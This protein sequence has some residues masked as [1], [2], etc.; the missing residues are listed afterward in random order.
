V[1]IHKAPA[2]YILIVLMAATAFGFSGCKQKATIK[3]PRSILDEKSATQEELMGIVNHYGKIR[4]LQARIKA[5]Y[6]S[7]LKEK[8][9]IELEKYPKAPG[10]IVL[11]RPDTTFLVINNPVMG[12]R[13][14]SFLSSGDEFRVWIHGKRTLYIGKN[15]SRELI[16][17]DGQEKL[18]IPIRAAHIYQALLPETIPTQD[19]DIRISKIEERDARASYYLLTEYREESSLF[20]R[21][22]RE[23]RIERQSLTLSR[24][25]IFDSE[26]RILSD[27]SYSN[28]KQH[29]T[30]FLPGEIH[31]E[32]PMDGYT[33][34]LEL[35]DW[36][37]NPDIKDEVFQLEPPDGVKVI[38]FK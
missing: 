8:D 14:I 37:T 24:Q 23:I 12:K 34:D 5:E 22:V 1:I 28:M 38:R 11:K 7:Q 18:K 27:I 20:L 30:F 26:G 4:T 6:T 19:R 15:S 31:M 32:R 2:S 35:K 29:D 17:D 10:L 25:R 9:Q 16:A 33:L 36:R 3:I 13:E 21:P